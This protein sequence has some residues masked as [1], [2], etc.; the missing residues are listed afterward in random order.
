MKNAG[1][2]GYAD[3]AIICILV[4][5]DLM[6]YFISGASLVTDLISLLF[7]GFISGYLLTGLFSMFDKLDPVE[8]LLAIV[9]ISA[10]IGGASFVITNIVLGDVTLTTSA[11]GVIL[12]S[13]LMVLVV[14]Y[15]R[16]KSKTGQKQGLWIGVLSD[17]GS[18]LGGMTRKKKVITLATF[19]VVAI[20]TIASIGILATVS[21][22]QYSELYIL[23]EQGAAYNLPHN[24]TVGS[25]QQI[26]LGIANHEGRPVTYFVEV[27][28]VNYTMVDGGVKV[29]HM[30]S[31]GTMNLTLPSVKVDLNAPWVPQYEQTLSL[32][33]SISGGYYLFFMLFQDSPR[34]LPLSPFDTHKDYATDPDATWR[35][36]DCVNNRIQFVRLNIN[37]SDMTSVT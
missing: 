9:T 20:I 15:H 10:M 21:K 4:V 7:L 32:N 28:L 23:N 19:G 6:S 37:I 5:F 14:I 1:L 2:N 17:L 30:Y 25:Q 26:I 34:S 27:W 29:I 12:L 33:F 24:F 31:Y 11:F 18:E 16:L 22:E 8:R 35:I 3:L 13:A 36:V